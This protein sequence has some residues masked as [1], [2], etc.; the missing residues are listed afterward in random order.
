M[1]PCRTAPL[2]S[3]IPDRMFPV[4]PGWIPTPVE[5]LL[6]S[7]LM[8]LSWFRNGSRGWRLLL[9]SIVAPSPFAHQW[10]GLIPVPINWTTNRFGGKLDAFAPSVVAP[11]TGRDS[12]HGKAM[13][14]PAPRRKMRRE[15]APSVFCSWFD[16]VFSSSLR[17]PLHVGYETVG[18]SLLYPPGYRN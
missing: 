12:S 5:G 9:N 10:F 16:I 17:Q 8:T 11:Q 13:T 18:S 14:T 4:M 1:P 3:G 7:P 15:S 2:V 6:K